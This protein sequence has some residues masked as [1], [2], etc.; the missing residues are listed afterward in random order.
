M[1]IPDHTRITSPTA[2]FFEDSFAE[3]IA[4]YRVRRDVSDYQN[5]VA[6]ALNKLGGSGVAFTP[7]KYQSNGRL[8][9]GFRITFSIGINQARIDCAA[10]PLRTHT[11]KKQATAMGQALYLLRNE[12]EAA[13]MAWVYKPGTMPLV[14]Y[15]IGPD[16]RTVAEALSDNGTIPLLGDGKNG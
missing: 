4:G 3:G 6:A 2:L 12:L 5:E 7:G 8:R 1:F 15:L 13:W 9:Q 10:L 14:P 11:D 16:G